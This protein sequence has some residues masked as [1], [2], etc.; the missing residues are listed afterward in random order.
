MLDLRPQLLRYMRT[1]FGF[2][3]ETAEDTLAGVGDRWMQRL[4]SPEPFEVGQPEAYLKAATRWAAIDQLRQASRRQEI[5]VDSNDWD[6]LEPYI[7]HTPS[8]EDVAAS[9]EFDPELVAK[10]RSLPHMQRR[11]IELS[12]LEDRSLGETAELL[13]LTRA[14]A[15]RHRLRA[16]KALRAMYANAQRS[17]R[18]SRPS[19]EQS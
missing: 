19:R 7:E 15:A 12:Y 13:G 1:Q 10:V 14:T 3:P 8:A 17:S 2:S 18:A 9:S 16:L 6:T 5:L 11:V 4:R